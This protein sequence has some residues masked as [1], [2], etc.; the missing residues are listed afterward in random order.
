MPSQTS[1]NASVEEKL[2]Q[3][4]HLCVLLAAA[5]EACKVRSDVKYASGTADADKSKSLPD[6]QRFLCKLAQICDTQKGGKTI[7]GL[8]CLRS[9]QGAEYLISSN[10]RKDTELQQTTEYLSGL[11]NYIATNPEDLKPKPLQKQVL[12]RILERNFDRLVIYLRELS[13]A[14]ESCIAD[15]SHGRGATGM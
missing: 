5:N 3:L 7:T 11:L 1:F 6:F 10:Q 2:A 4:Q 9:P 15:F 13:G 12:W 14:L 8:V